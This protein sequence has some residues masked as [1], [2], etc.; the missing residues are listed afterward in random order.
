MSRRWI[1]STCIVLVFLAGFITVIL[2]GAK[3]GK[4][5]SLK[6]QGTSL[7]EKVS[8]E[9]A[10]ANLP[11]RENTAVYITKSGT[12]Y[13]LSEDCTGLKKAK[14]IIKTTLS[15]AEDDGKELCKICEE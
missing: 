13:H 10:L 7:S 5:G 15:A 11:D 14:E 2:L 4:T 9:E 12:K 6:T 1:Q 8:W 3:Q